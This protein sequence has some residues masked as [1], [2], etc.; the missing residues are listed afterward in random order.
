MERPWPK[1]HDG[2][3]TLAT[4]VTPSTVLYHD[5]RPLAFTLYGLL[6]FRTLDG[7]F[8]YIDEQAGR[9][10]FATGSERAQFA[11]ALMR[12][13]I[14]SRVVSMVTE[15]PLQLLLAH[16]LEDLDASVACL[17]DPLFVGHHWAV[18]RADYRLALGRV[19]ERWRQA[20]NCW[21]GSSSPA[22]RVLSN[23]Y[24][25]EEGIELFDARYDS[26][27]H[28]WQA[29]KY[30]PEVSVADVIHLLEALDQFDRETWLNRLDRDQDVYLANAH[31]VEFLRANLREEQRTRFR[32]QLLAQDPSAKARGLQQRGQAGVR[33]SALQEK[34]LW[35]D[36][37]D[38]F[39][40]LV[41]FHHL[42]PIGNAPLLNL[43][44]ALH[45]DAVYLPD[46]K[47]GFISPEFRAVMLDIWKVKF[48][49]TP[50]LG[51]VIRSIPREVKLDHFLNDSDSPDIPLAIYVEYLNHIRQVAWDREIS[52]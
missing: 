32:E 35:G 21:S 46:R 6:Q 50:R 8:V 3:L 28:F 23:W 14:E 52:R 45:F 40:L 34:T 42:V 33:F 24:L 12:R 15:E 37:A 1:A 41:H 31:A 2:G 5:N 7:L 30:H 22:G 36:L 10:Q 44:Q 38:L 26:T 20:L 16:T 39:H 9:W 13:G 49:E 51:E 27:E 18:A 48:L 19:R 43:L 47:V 11:N 29:I 4:L 17:P 25:I